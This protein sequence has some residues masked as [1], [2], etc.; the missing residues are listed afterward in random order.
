MDKRI[1]KYIGLNKV[2]TLAT[3]ID[4]TPYCANCFYAHDEETDTLIFLSDNST[5]H[6]KEAIENKTVAGTIQNGVTIVSEIKGV[7]FRGEM[8]DIT[9]KEQQEFYS[10]YYKRFPFAKGK[11]SPIWVVKLNWIKMTDNSLGFGTKLIWER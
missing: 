6:I 3:S 7:Q 11:P 2:F 9:E 4:N 8:I 1:L 5:R 10:I